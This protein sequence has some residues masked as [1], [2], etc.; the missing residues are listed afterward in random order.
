MSDQRQI[1]DLLESARRHEQPIPDGASQ[2]VWRALR[3]AEA[4]PQRPFW[5]VFLAGAA[6]TGLVLLLVPRASHE[7]YPAGTLLPQASAIELHGVAELVTGS[8][9]K[10]RVERNDTQRVELRVDAG[11]LLLHVLPRQ[12]RGPFIVRTPQF[13]ARVVGT[14]FRVL[15]DG[16]GS[17]ITVA[18]GTVEVTPSGGAATPIHAHEAWPE[19][20]N[21]AP[22]P[23]ELALLATREQVA[24]QDFV[25]RPA[26]VS[27]NSWNAGRCVKSA[28]APRIRNGAISVHDNAS[29]QGIRGTRS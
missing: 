2:R 15:V 23:E 18:H 4:R 19:N 10:V 25:A 17:H 8:G 9:S 11:S 28:P 5:P 7:P 26:H 3:V 27:S 24:I 14:V 29:R 22:G 12:G 20:A 1:A 16:S 13:V 6:L 21:V